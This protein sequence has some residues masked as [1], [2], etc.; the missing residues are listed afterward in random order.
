VVKA[1]AGGYDDW[2][3]QRQTEAA[4]PPKAAAMQAPEPAKPK[5][6]KLTNK[7]RHELDQ[8]E[9]R[10]DALETEQ[11]KLVADLADADFYKRPAPEI[12]AAQARSAEIAQQIE[13]LMAR[14][15]ELEAN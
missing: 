6:R 10:I 9:S 1:Y 2:L 3:M 7:E 8:M 4:S 15:T 14:W 12:A 13:Q 5:A 11:A